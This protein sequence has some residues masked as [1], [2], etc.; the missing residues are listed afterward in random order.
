MSWELGNLQIL[1]TLN[2]LSCKTRLIA[3]SSFVS[4]SLVWNTIPNDPLPTILQDVYDISRS[5]PVRPSC[6]CSVTVFEN[7]SSWTTCDRL[8]SSPWKDRAPWTSKHPLK[9][10]LM[11]AK[12]AHCYDFDLD[13]S[14]VIGVTRQPKVKIHSLGNTIVIQLGCV[15][16]PWMRAADGL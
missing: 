16:C 10:C 1:L 6:T 12:A 9:S 4:I 15:D 5:S 7:Q 14:R 13:M 11:E 8:I 2:R 3:A